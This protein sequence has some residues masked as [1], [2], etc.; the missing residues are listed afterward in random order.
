MAA[1]F[2]EELLDLVRE[3]RAIVRPRFP[4]WLR[5]FLMR[6]VAGI[7]LGRRIYLSPA[8]NA[9]SVESLLR[10]ELAHVRQINRLGILRFYWRYAVEFLRNVRGGMSVSD[11]YRHISFEEEAFAAETYNRV[12]GTTE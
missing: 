12:P 10:H 3:A 5:P 4:W 7:T 9:S 2:S 6:D 11:A 8:A 1:H